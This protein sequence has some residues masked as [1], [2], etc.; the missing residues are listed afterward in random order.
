M[1]NFLFAALLAI[2]G[3]LCFTSPGGVIC[4]GIVTEF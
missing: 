3:F 2:P 4:P 1:V